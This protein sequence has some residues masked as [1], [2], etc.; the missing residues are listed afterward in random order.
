MAISHFSLEYHCH[1]YGISGHGCGCG[2]KLER[3]E[4]TVDGHFCHMVATQGSGIIIPISFALI[5][6]IELH[7]SMSISQEAMYFCL[8]GQ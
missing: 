2:T 7:L 4:Q 8:Q 6:F 3:A 1:N 5:L